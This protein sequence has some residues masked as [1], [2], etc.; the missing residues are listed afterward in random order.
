MYQQREV[1]ESYPCLSDF[2]DSCLA[3]SMMS[4]LDLFKPSFSRLESEDTTSLWLLWS[5]DTTYAMLQGYVHISMHTWN[6]CEWP[7]G[8]REW[9]GYREAK[10]EKQNEGVLACMN[11]SVSWTK[12]TGWILWTWQ[13]G[14]RERCRYYTSES[15]TLHVH[16]NHLVNLILIYYIWGGPWDSAFLPSS[17]VKLL[18]AASLSSKDIEGLPFP[19]WEFSNLS[20]VCVHTHWSYASEELIKKKKQI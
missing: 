7:M 3:L 14:E 19:S 13:P 5:E 4:L 9:S 2:S 10:L 20:D 6:T 11:H 12:K 8:K 16:V 18:G 1:C 15:Q 17:Q